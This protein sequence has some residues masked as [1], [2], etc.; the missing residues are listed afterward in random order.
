MVT[1]QATG[2]LTKTSSGSDVSGVSVSRGFGLLK[3]DV[4]VLAV[5][6]VAG[7]PELRPRLLGMVEPAAAIRVD[8]ENKRTRAPREENLIR[9][10]LREI[11]GVG[12]VLQIW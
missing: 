9:R 12:T 6:V 2:F 5:V 11:S 7:V 1:V 8:L 3:G 10:V 4:E